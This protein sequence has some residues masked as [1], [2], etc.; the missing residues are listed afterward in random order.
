MVEAILAWDSF[1]FLL[2]IINQGKKSIGSK[3]FFA[4]D[5][6]R[7]QNIFRLASFCKF[8]SPFS[9]WFDKVII[10][11]ILIEESVGK[12]GKIV[13]RRIKRR[14]N[15]ASPHSDT[16]EQ[17]RSIWGAFSAFWRQLLTI[18]W[19]TAFHKSR[20]SQSPYVNVPICIFHLNFPPGIMWEIWPSVDK[21]P[22]HGRKKS[23]IYAEAWLISW[24]TPTSVNHVR[25]RLE[26]AKLSRKYKKP[27]SKWSAINPLVRY[28]RVKTHIFERGFILLFYA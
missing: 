22:S 21:S 2:D 11:I 18:L 8:Y 6:N 15:D 27:H 9:A 26:R 1:I 20:W 7:S 19:Q 16:N 12:S 14:K 23:R 10:I 28:F 25:E 5:P 17:D 13:W 24:S 3:V 4:I